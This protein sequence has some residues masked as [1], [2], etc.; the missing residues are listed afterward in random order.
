MKKYFAKLVKY[1][2][3]IYQIERGL[4]QLIDERINSTCALAKVV[5]IVLLFFYFDTR[6]ECVKLNYVV[7]YSVGYTNVPAIVY[8]ALIITI[9][10]IFLIVTKSNILR[11]K[12]MISGCI[13]IAFIT[14]IISLGAI[15]S[16][17]SNIIALK[18]GD[19]KIIEGEVK[20]F[21]PAASNLKDIE[22]FKVNEKT[23]KYSN[24]SLNG[25]LNHSIANVVNN[26]SIVK[27]YYRNDDIIRLEIKV[28]N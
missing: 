6:K 4:N 7:V 18:H 2:E 14:G 8:V 22:T 12:K 27:V 16:H 5:K 20:N 10:I 26:G 11:S 1:M 24:S 28:N 19:Y 3:N 21:S 25:G 15:Y 9:I 23:F 13:F 17:F